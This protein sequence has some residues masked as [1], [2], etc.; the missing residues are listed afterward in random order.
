MD[1]EL[2]RRI[3]EIFHQAL[4]IPAR[5]RDAFIA[6]ECAGNKELLAHVVRL[7]RDDAVSNPLFGSS[8]SEPRALRPDPL[9]GRTFGAYRLTSRIAAGGMGVVYR[10]ERCDGLFDQ[11]VAVKLIRT[12]TAS[13]DMFRR[14]EFERRMLAALSHPNIAR[15]FDGGTSEEGSPYLVMEFINGQ[16][17]DQYCDDRR[18]S[19]PDRLKL[20]TTICRAVHYAH[21]NQIV[22]RDLKPGNILIDEQ[23]QPKLLDFGIARLVMAEESKDAPQLTRT[24]SRI[25]TPEYASPEQFSGGT[26]TTA[27]DIYSLGVVLYGLLTGRRPFRW[28]SRSPGEWERIVKEQ[29]PTRPSTA[30]MRGSEHATGGL[31]SDPRSFAARCRT[32]PNKLRHRLAGDLDR[33]VLMALKKEPER[34]Y[35]SAQEFAE[36]VERHLNGQPVIAREDSVLYRT[37]KFIQR[38]RLAASAC[39]LIFAALLF[40]IFAA[41]AGEKRARSQAAHARIEADS[42]RTIAGFMMDMCLTSGVLLSEEERQRAEKRILM[43]ADLV[44]RQYEQQ[45]HLRANLLEALGRACLQLDLFGEAEALMR[46]SLELRQEEFGERSLEVA[47]SLGSLGELYYRR[48]QYGEAEQALGKALELHRT[49]DPGT[50]TDVATAANDLAVVLRRRGDNEGAERLHLE[51]LEARRSSGDELAVAESLNNLAGIY[52]DR[53]NSAQCAEL[54]SEART[55]RAQ[56]LGEEHFLYLQTLSNLAIATAASDLTKARDMFAEAEAG[57]RALH[58]EGKRELGQVLANR[59]ALDQITGDLDGAEKRLAEALEI[60]RGRLGSDHPT[61]GSILVKTADIHDLRGETE[62]AQTAWDEALRVYRTSLDASN[63]KL[64]R[65]LQK[66]GAFLVGIGELE[67]AESALRESV[68]VLRSSG[69]PVSGSLARAELTLG[70]CLFKGGQLDE[71]ERRLQTGME[72]LEEAQGISEEERRIAHGYMEDL[73]RLRN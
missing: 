38:N 14:F 64:G 45:V 16:P 32:T 31:Q 43:Q 28:E 2:W 12:E 56:L 8:R 63:P 53:R 40:G 73:Q 54:L 34:R 25:L 29:A 27:T 68:E 26:F 47:L 30:V 69:S 3:E 59:A 60:E 42:F 52:L 13:E 49:C 35:A 71:A 7:I 1:P 11:N 10:A 46:E 33:I 15:L 17:I 61:V 5:E 66:Y 20:F 18:L 39:G 6:R 51:A 21:Q 65:T 41:R 4:E 19:I 23:G 48:G 36:D 24:L 22:H 55:I 62:D 72:L 57:Y 9:V 44:R 37:T 58:A 67:R 50:H 70:R